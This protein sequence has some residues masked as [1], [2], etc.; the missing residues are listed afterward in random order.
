MTLTVTGPILETAAWEVQ[1]LLT[2]ISAYG[3][4]STSGYVEEQSPTEFWYEENTVANFW[5]ED[6]IITSTGDEKVVF[7]GWTGGTNGTTIVAPLTVT[8]NWHTEY[9]VTV[10]NGGHGT[11]PAPEWVIDG[12]TY[13]LAIENLLEE[14]DT[15]YRFSGWTS[16]NGYEGFDNEITLTVTSPIAE[17]ATWIIEYSLTIISVHGSDSIG[18]PIGAGWYEDGS[19]ATLSIEQSVTIL[20]TIFTFENWVGTV[21]DPNSASTTLV[22]NEPKLINVEWSSQPVPDEPDSQPLDLMLIIPIVLIVV[23]VAVVAILLMKRGKPVEDE[24]LEMGDEEDSVEEPSG[25]E[26][27]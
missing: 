20:D 13:D 1:H 7:D 2:I 6:V 11:E 17:T 3:T 4:I 5:T 16:L 24:V 12:E 14:T 26:Y 22:M 15:R 19:T 23:V 9:L 18:T 21:A 27:I 8:V 25:E 10:D